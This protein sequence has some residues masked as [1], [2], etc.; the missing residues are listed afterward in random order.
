MGQNWV[1]KRSDDL[2]GVAG[3][4]LEIRVV[5]TPHTWRM[6]EHGSNVASV[7][8]A[9]S[10]KQQYLEKAVPEDRDQLV[11][12]LD[13]HHLIHKHPTFPRS[14]CPVPLLLTALGWKKKGP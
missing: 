5:I 7:F 11:K 9:A 6:E 10:G 3:S 12:G 8:Q 13:H 2:F 1:Q 4:S 14:R